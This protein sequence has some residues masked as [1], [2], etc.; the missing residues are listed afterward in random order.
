MG[1]QTSLIQPSLPALDDFE[2]SI[3][4][5]DAALKPFLA[6][7][8][9]KSLAGSLPAVDRARLLV[10]HGYAI[11]TLLFSACA[12]LLWLP[13]HAASPPSL[14]VTVYLDAKLLFFS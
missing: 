2:A 4:G 10:S 8:S 13:V 1:D 3:N 6:M 11:F 12:C 9:L 14:C 7:P 5:I